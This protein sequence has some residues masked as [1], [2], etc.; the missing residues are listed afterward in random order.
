MKIDSFKILALKQEDAK[1]LNA[2]M[3]SNQERFKKFFPKTLSDNLTLES[4]Q[5]YI[6]EKNEK[7][8]SKTEFT[9]AIKEN[10]SQ[11]IAGLI[12]I[13]KVNWDIKQGEFAYC[14]GEN[15]KGNGLIIK[16]IKVV[17]DFAF[18]TL[19]LKTLQIISHKSNLSSIKVAEN[20]NFIWRKTLQNEFKPTDE[21]PL[22]MELYELIR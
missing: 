3:V 22:D 11:E 17:S 15:Y 4:S 21:P 18:E 5:N 12:I 14:L 16:A 19:K 13:K 8:Q 7:M 10:E 20:N 6:L 2:L 1:S 9:F